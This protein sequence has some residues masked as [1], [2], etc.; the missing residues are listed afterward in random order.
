MTDYKDLLK[1]VKIKP[2]IEDFSDIN[3]NAGIRHQLA[4]VA[5]NKP[6]KKTDLSP[7][8]ELGLKTALRELFTKGLQ[9]LDK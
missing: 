5:T 3:P 7:S 6:G 1:Y 8:N 9:I 4:G 2:T